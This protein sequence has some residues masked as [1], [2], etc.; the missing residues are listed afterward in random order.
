MKN[1]FLRVALAWLFTVSVMVAPQLHAQQFDFKT[2]QAVAGDFANWKMYT[3]TNTN[4]TSGSKTITLESNLVTIPGIG[5]I[6][7]IQAN[8]PVTVDVGSAQETVTI[9]SATCNATSCSLTATFSNSHSGRVPVTSGTNGAQEA[10]DFL[11]NLGGVGAVIIQPQFPGATSVLTGL[12][13]GSASIT[14][15]DWRMG[16]T[17]YNWS[18]SAYGP[19]YILS[20]NITQFV[21][22]TADTPTAGATFTPAT[23]LTW[24]IPANTVLKYPFHCV[25]T[26]TQATAA[27][28]NA[29]GIQTATNA[30]TNGALN[31]ITTTAAAV[32]ARAS[33]TG[34]NV[35]TA[36]TIVTGT[37]GAAGT[38]EQVIL[39]G[40]IE[41][42]SNT[43]ASV[44]TVGV[45]TT[46]GGTDI[47]TIKRGS[48]CRLF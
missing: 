15:E 1:K 29:F 41:Q 7:P 32:V 24:T 11:S 9:S 36:Q 20:S 28:A 39:D 21:E 27:T 22:A 48:Y 26:W 25:L 44:V 12:V 35:N 42:P 2:R 46:S 13:R 14:V 16:T 17:F 30:P 23:G 43:T 8:S 34:Y 47:T 37:P 3:A 4:I 40:F 45:T 38:T 5:A 10:L 6:S 18:G 33:V 31:G 19:A